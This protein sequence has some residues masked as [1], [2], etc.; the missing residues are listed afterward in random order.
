MHRQK[1]QPGAA[2]PHTPGEHLLNPFILRVPLKHFQ[3][4]ACARGADSRIIYHQENGRPFLAY[5]RVEG[6]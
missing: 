3:I 4:D 2:G 1:V 6:P 5:S